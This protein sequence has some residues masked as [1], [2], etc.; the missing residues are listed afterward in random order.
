MMFMMTNCDKKSSR[1]R[2]LPE[3]SS[4]RVRLEMLTDYLDRYTGQ[5]NKGWYNS[6]RW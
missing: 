1:T 6:D 5:I 2:R 4:Q 3:L